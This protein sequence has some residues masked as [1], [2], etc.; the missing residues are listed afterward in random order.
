MSRLSL[1]QALHVVSL[2]EFSY[3]FLKMQNGIVEI[4]DIIVFKCMIYYLLL[5]NLQQPVVDYI[6]VHR[7]RGTLKSS[8][9][10]RR[11]RTSHVAPARAA[12]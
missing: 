11:S 12:I 3:P 1:S 6:R 5:K 10:A 4:H 2:Y 7:K 8:Q 9:V